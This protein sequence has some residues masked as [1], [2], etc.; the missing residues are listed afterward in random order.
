MIV[1]RTVLFNI[2]FIGWSILVC[3][4]LSWT[5]L[6]RRSVLMRVVVFY[7]K[8]IGVLERVFLGLSYV[9]EG[10]ENLPATGTFIV[11]AK[12]QSAWETLKLQ[13]LFTDPAIVLKKE[14]ERI[15]LWGTFAR[16]G[17]MIFVD[18]S[19]PLRAMQSLIRGAREVAARGRPIIIFPQGT[20]LP[21]G[22]YEP[23]HPGVAAVYDRLK[24]PVIPMA[25][26]AGMFWPRKGFLKRPGVITVSFLPPIPPGLPRAEMMERLERDLEAE[27]DRLVMAVGGPATV[28]P[29]AAAPAVHADGPDKG[30]KE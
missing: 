6:M 16:K 17:D 13:E 24:L 1:I 18:R 22:A 27:T 26:N 10:R 4:S 30:G 7:M 9:V 2:A 23:Y 8:S 15:P 21:P 11:A 29:P 5:L 28:R 14:L 3:T 20:R 19:A 12:H 25:H